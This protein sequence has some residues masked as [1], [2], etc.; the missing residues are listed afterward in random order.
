MDKPSKRFVLVKYPSLESL[1]I[2]ER[3][4]WEVYV[5]QAK[6]VGRELSEPLAESDDGVEL[7]RFRA[8]TEEE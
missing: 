5:D 4:T 2:L 7:H 8:L 3:R 6:H 1:F